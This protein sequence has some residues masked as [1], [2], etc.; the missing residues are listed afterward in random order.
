MPEQAIQFLTFDQ[1]VEAA[2]KEQDIEFI[3]IRFNPPYRKLEAACV[4][5]QFWRQAA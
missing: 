3:G 1:A 2:K 5:N 4:F